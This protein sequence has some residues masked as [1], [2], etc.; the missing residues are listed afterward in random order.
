MLAGRDG[1]CGGGTPDMLSLPL[2]LTT[3]RAVYPSLPTAG[4]YIRVYRYPGGTG[5]AVLGSHRAAGGLLLLVL[6]LLLVAGGGAL[7]LLLPLHDCRSPKPER[8]GWAPAQQ[9][10]QA[11]K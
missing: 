5:M 9:L 4:R 2:V 10:P 1:A 6:L 7:P 8:T 11:G 3:A